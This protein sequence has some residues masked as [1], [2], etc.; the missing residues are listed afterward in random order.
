M[1]PS[2][3]T[4]TELPDPLSETARA[5]WLNLQHYQL[6]APALPAGSTEVPVYVDA[7]RYLWDVKSKRRFKE[8]NET[9]YLV[10][11]GTGTDSV[12]IH[13][14]SRTLLMVP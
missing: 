5:A 3:I 4:A 8:N 10:L 11:K 12:N 2:G 13:Y 14:A 9:L 6:F 1:G 7:Q